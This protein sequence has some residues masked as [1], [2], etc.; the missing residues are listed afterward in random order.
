MGD[1]RGDG[2]TGENVGTQGWTKGC[3]ESKASGQPMRGAKGVAH[4]RIEMALGPNNPET[5]VTVAPRKLGPNCPGTLVSVP[6]NTLQLNVRLQESP[7]S[8]DD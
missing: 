1:T 7:D 5:I 8:D 6:R 2:A 3:E 4:R